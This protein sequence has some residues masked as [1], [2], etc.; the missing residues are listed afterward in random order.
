MLKGLFNLRYRK[1]LTLYNEPLDIS[2]Q[3]YLMMRFKIAKSYQNIYD[4]LFR[5]AN[6]H[7][8]TLANHAK[9][10]LLFLPSYPKLKSQIIEPLDFT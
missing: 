10:L 7:D 1:N 4:I 3:Y 8:G 9:K 5:L 6:H 2:N